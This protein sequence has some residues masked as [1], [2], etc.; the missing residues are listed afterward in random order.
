ML[1]RNH[2]HLSERYL[3]FTGAKC[4]LR[5][6]HCYMPA[7]TPMQV[8]AWKICL[9]LLWCRICRMKDIDLTGGEAL[10]HPHIDFIVSFACAIGYREVRILTNGNNVRMARNLEVKYPKIKFSVSFHSHIDFEGFSIYRTGVAT[11]NVRMFIKWHGDYI[12]YV[13]CCPSVYNQNMYQTLLWIHKM[14]PH[15]VICIKM[16]GYETG[17]SVPDF[18]PYH[19]TNQAVKRLLQEC[20][21]AR[22]DF[23]C[24]GHCHIDKEL[25]THPNVNIISEHNNLYDKMDWN[26]AITSVTWRKPWLWIPYIFGTN[27]MREWVGKKIVPDV[28]KHH[29]MAYSHKCDECIYIGECDGMEDA[30]YKR[31]GFDN[32]VA[33]RE[34]DEAAN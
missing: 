8:S 26:A 12:S 29:K 28:V 7:N 3:I 16:L 5:C 9:K 6:V 22:I 33:I 30:Y 25:R 24:F 19:I 11:E 15:A 2:N 27:R 4:N 14:V 21:K 10:L 13:N 20:P 34:P 18:L 31:F 1:P 17:E 32:E 23:R